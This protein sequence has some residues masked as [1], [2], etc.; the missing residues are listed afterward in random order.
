MSSEKDRFGLSW[1]K[2]AGSRREALRSRLGCGEG[3]FGGFATVSGI[4]STRPEMIRELDRRIPGL[5]MI[6]TKSYQ[7]V[8][9]PGNREPIIVETSAG[10]FGNAVGLRN[11][12]M[13]KALEE[14]IRLR[15]SWKM[16]ALLNVS[17]SGSSPEEFVRLAEG[18]SPVA[19]TLELNFSCPHAAPGYG[20][21]IGVDPELVERYVKAI[22]EVT[23]LPLLPKLTPNTED[24]GA[25]AE[26]AMRAGADGLVAVNTFGPELYIEKHSGKPILMNIHG[27]KGGKSG[28]WIHREAV[29]KVRSIREQVGAD[30]LI[31][32]M[33]GVEDATGVIA[34]REA[35]ADVVGIGSAFAMVRPE[36]WEGWFEELAPSDGAEKNGRTAVPRIEKPQMVYRPYRI[37][38]ARSGIGG[39]R[40]I[41]LDGRVP[42]EAGQFVFLWIPGVG[43]KPFSVALSDP[44]TFLV[45]ER[46]EMTRAL[47]ALEAGDTLY[48]RGMYGSGARL[49]AT[50]RAWILAG[51]T[52]LAVVPTLAS[53][54]SGRGSKLSIFMALSDREA[55]A[56]TMRD[57]DTLF[58]KEL[59]ALGSYQVVQDDGVIGRA[60]KVFAGELAAEGSAAESA[61]YVIG[62]APFMEAAAATG[63]AAGIPADRISL[64]IETSTRCGVG[65]CGECVCAGKLTCREGTFFT[66][67]E[68]EVRG[69]KPGDFSDDH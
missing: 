64:S 43:E 17:L 48:M 22:R 14:L 42:F 23:D 60:V 52:G 11:P 62:P 44:L 66:L 12:G 28:R 67:T 53:A 27:G 36:D 5:V 47:C 18:F 40:R 10:S 24:I 25:V 61:L 63:R 59:S 58:S 16:R 34:M 50:R 1:P 8:P 3:R 31:I 35:G 30:P 46:G 2:D 6:T 21:S 65:L 29:E 4:L 37:R 41:T 69:V 57:A 56:G 38:S 15:S 19:D 13:E 51:G 49:P 45:R 7:L 26:A 54:L 32:G 68:L 20:M 33:G 9:N 55:A 39:L